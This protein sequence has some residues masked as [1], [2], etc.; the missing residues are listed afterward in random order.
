MNRKGFTPD[1]IETIASPTA[2]DSAW[3]AAA[4]RAEQQ[5]AQ[6]LPPPATPCFTQADVDE[7]LARKPQKY[8]MTEKDFQELGRNMVLG[9]G[10][11]LQG[12]TVTAVVSAGIVAEVIAESSIKPIP[13]DN[14]YTWNGYDYIWY[15]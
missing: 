1:D 3:A 10:D 8:Q 15:D 11:L 2:S 12:A 4:D 13:E 14:Y 9:V 5:L 6:E 7:F